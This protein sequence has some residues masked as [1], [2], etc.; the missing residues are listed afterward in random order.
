MKRFI[1]IIPLL[2][3]AFVFIN[4]RDIRRRDNKPYLNRFLRKLSKAPQKYQERIN[5]IYGDAKFE[6]YQLKIPRRWY[7]SDKFKYIRATL[8]GETVNLFRQIA[9]SPR[10]NSYFYNGEVLKN[11]KNRERTRYGN[12]SVTYQNKQASG[13]IVLGNKIAKIVTLAPNTFALVEIKKPDQYKCGLSHID[14]EKKEPKYQKGIIIFDQSKRPK[15][16]ARR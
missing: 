13:E 6:I 2:V 12:V 7:P 10:P 1:L 4:A 16:E 15:K 9:Y 8:L 14:V 3:L 11:E 5:N